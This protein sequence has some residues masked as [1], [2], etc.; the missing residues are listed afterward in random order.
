MS[1]EPPPALLLRSRKRTLL[2]WFVAGSLAAHVAVLTLAP[3]WLA[4]RAVPPPPLT[5]ALQKE[6][7][8]QIV[9]PRPL[10]VETRPERVERL[11]V[12]PAAQP[13]AEPPLEQ[14][15]ILTAPP[16]APRAPAAAAV[17]EQ[18]P[19][20]ET[21]RPP[22]PAPPAPATVVPPRSDAVFL[23]DAR[24]A[25]PMAAR[26][27]GDQGTVLVRVMVTADGRAASATLEKTSGHAAL[28]EAALALVRGGRF[29]PARQGAQAVESLHVVPI[30]FK[31][32]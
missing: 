3:A 13:V 16:E 6:E 23:S 11:P 32:D 19:V 24:A 9:A 15:T 1:V 8:P 21:T 12:K 26:R 20:P 30:V 10:P 28:D 18:K 27:R 5:V 22:T 2:T 17:A 31:L 7:P 14:K 4:R 25:Y 29:T